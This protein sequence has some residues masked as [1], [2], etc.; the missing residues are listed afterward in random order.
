MTRVLVCGDRAWRERDYLERLLDAYH[1]ANPISLVIEGH[2]RG[3]DVMAFLWAESRG[4]P[5]Q[6]FPAD[7]ARYGRAA[8]PI[9]NREMLNEGRPDVVIAFHRD[10][11]RSKGTAD[12]VKIAR[13]AGVTTYVFPPRVLAKSDGSDSGAA[14]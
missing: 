5:V 4:V 7:W 1:A 14:A 6:A 2:A 3:A 11:S 12:M 8:G 13:Q 10:L 9:R